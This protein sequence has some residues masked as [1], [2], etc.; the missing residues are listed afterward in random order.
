LPKV[1]TFRNSFKTVKKAAE[2]KGKVE[3]DDGSHAV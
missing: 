3:E 1:E 2:T